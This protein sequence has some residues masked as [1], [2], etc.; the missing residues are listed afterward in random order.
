MQGGRYDAELGKKGERQ[1][2]TFNADTTANFS[3]REPTI[4]TLQSF[5]HQ[6]CL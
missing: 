4:T 3:H 1:P 2:E 6:T 5:R